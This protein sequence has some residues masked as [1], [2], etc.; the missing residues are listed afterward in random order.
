MSRSPLAALALGAGLLA[1]GCDGDEAKAKEPAGAAQPAAEAEPSATSDAA[2]KLEGRIA[3]IRDKLAKG[4]NTSFMC[5]GALASK[6]TLASSTDASEKEAYAT[7]QQV[8]YVEQPKALIAAIR[9]KIEAGEALKSTESVNLQTVLKTKGFPTEGEPAEV[10]ADAKR[11]MEVEIPAFKIDGHL[12]TAQEE[13]D[14]GK[15]VSMGCIKAKQIVE[16][17]KPALEADETAKA[18]LGRYAEACPG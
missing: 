15:K 17:S 10:V 18:V 4:D 2:K 1:S 16:K 11:L 12:V 6:A 14:A 8:C 5:V 9:K 13:R 3:E 7:L